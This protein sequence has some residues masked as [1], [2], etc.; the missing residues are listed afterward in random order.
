MAQATGDLP[1]PPGD[2]TGHSQPSVDAG[3]SSHPSPVQPI[4]PLIPSSGN[5][6]FIVAHAGVV[7]AEEVML[8][9]RCPDAHGRL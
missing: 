8:V 9:P 7:I 1:H 6:V 3:K 2:A 4:K 5:T